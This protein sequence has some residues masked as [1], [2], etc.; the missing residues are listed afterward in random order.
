MNDL[1]E[2]R[3]EGSYSHAISF[4]LSSIITSI[5]SDYRFSSS[6]YRKLHSYL[7]VAKKYD[8]DVLSVL[9]YLYLIETAS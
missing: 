6:A 9:R 5:L 3:K 4:Q 7:R 1:R 8:I 2:V